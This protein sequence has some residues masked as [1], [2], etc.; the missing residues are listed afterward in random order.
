MVIA[1]M[2]ELFQI[3]RGHDPEEFRQKYIGDPFESKVDEQCL[4]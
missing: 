1:A 3:E 4:I 2:L